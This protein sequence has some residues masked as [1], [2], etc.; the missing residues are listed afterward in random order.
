M[1]AA[2]ATLVGSLAVF[3]ITAKTDK[4]DNITV[5]AA[6][7]TNV[8]GALLLNQAL[9]LEYEI[10]STGFVKSTFSLILSS[11]LNFLNY[12]DARF[13]TIIT[14]EWAEGDQSG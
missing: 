7:D 11:T 13:L 1:V 2:T 6:L 4:T 3:G 10:Q 5:R 8:S 12:T 9:K 14:L